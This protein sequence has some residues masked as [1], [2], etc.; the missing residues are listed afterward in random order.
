ML[1]LL[2]THALGGLNNE[3]HSSQ[4]G[5]GGRYLEGSRRL[6]QVD[7]GNRYLPLHVHVCRRR[8]SVLEQRSS[9]QPIC[10]YVL[11]HTSQPWRA[12]NAGRMDLRVPCGQW[13]AVTRLLVAVLVPT[14]S[15]A[16]P[17]SPR[18]PGARAMGRQI[19]L[20]LNA[21]FPAPPQSRLDLG[22]VPE[23]LSPTEDF[24]S[25]LVMRRQA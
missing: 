4:P 20:S 13:M 6:A 8:G 2:V 22:E 3:G 7:H 19:H 10:G 1:S 23:T 11:T 16:G 18:F 21:E 17:S 25:K 5:P 12:Q 9:P 24:L 15:R 14:Q